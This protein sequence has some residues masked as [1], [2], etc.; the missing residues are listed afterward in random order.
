M[1][2]NFLLA[3]FAAIATADYS[4]APF[5]RNSYVYRDGSQL[6][7][8]GRNWT[9]QGANVYWCEESMSR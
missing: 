8:D 9:A 1:I 3:T 5:N 4:P 6:K 2:A 7:I